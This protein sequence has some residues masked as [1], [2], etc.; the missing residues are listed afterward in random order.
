M[1][2]KRPLKRWT[3]A[4]YIKDGKA[5]GYMR[6]DKTGYW[7]SASDAEAHIAYLEAQVASLTKECD[8]QYE[9]NAGQIALVAKLEKALSMYKG[10]PDGYGV[11]CADVILSPQEDG[12][13]ATG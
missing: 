6:G 13:E 3:T 7:V 11:Y 1:A 5:Y 10:M 2:T 12:K 4:A 9:F 8:R